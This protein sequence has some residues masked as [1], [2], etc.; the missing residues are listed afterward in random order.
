MISSD[1][2]R[3][4]LLEV[5]N[6]QR[7]SW[8]AI[9]YNRSSPFL[10][11]LTLGLFWLS[12]YSATQF[13]P[14]HIPTI[15]G[16]GMVLFS[17]VMFWLSLQSRQSAVTPQVQ[18]INRNMGIMFGLIVPAFAVASILVMWPVSGLKIGAFL[19]LLYAAIY[20]GMGLWMGQRYV[21]VGVAVFAAT[22]AGYYL[23]REYFS[24][25]MAIVC[26]GSMILTGLWLRNA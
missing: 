4:S 20:T 5:E 13:W 16:G 3:Q 9:G 8:Q 12:C 6:T 22:L 14:Q 19:P 15:W 18:R 11:T 10:L 21:I 25:W 23:L 17:G 24:L 7:Q 1:E 2:A 26:G